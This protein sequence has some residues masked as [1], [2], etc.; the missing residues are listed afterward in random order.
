MGATLI[1]HTSAGSTNGGSSVTTAS[2]DTT[3]A[4]HIFIWTA[5]YLPAGLGTL[6]DSKTNTWTAFA[7]SNTVSDIAGTLYYLEG[8]SLGSGHTFTVSGV[9]NY[10]SLYVFAF[11]GVVNGGSDG[12]TDYHSTISPVTAFPV[13][14]GFYADE[15]YLWGFVSNLD[16][17]SLSIGGS[18]VSLTIVEQLAYNAGNSFGGALAW[19]VHYS[20]P[21]NEAPTYA[22]TTSGATAELASIFGWQSTAQTENMGWNRPTQFEERIQLS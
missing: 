22:F 20:G 7:A 2:I 21:G 10:P 3:G 9:T 4:S 17:S 19:G 11:S 16:Y 8:G 14:A 13:Y 5:T 1:A 18:G 12:R 15:L 6:S